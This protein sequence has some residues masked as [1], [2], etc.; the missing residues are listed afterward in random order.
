MAFKLLSGVKDLLNYVYD[1][2]AELVIIA[3][4]FT[5]FYIVGFFTTL[6]YQGT[7]GTTT[8]ITQDN[9]AYTESISIFSSI[10][11]FIFT[12]TVNS[13]IA[14]IFGLALGFIPVLFAITNGLTIGMFV[15][16]IIP[17]T[18]ILSLLAAIVPYV[19]FQIPAILLSSA[20]GLRLGHSLLKAFRGRKGM[21]TEAKK[22]LTVFVFLILPLIV[23]AG[24]A[25]ATISNP[26]LLSI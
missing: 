17:K 24:I 16:S 26:I 4:I 20:I 18:D 15:G 11:G 2:R 12:N 9:A 6:N 8:S 1:L 23:L 19:A 7:Q 25:Q 3:I 13:M 22:G 10:T 14:I 21:L 5:I